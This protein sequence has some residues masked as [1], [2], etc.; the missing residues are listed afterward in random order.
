MEP[1]DTNWEPHAAQLRHQIAGILGF[2]AEKGPLDAETHRTID[3]GAYTI[4]PVTFASEP[5][6]RVTALLYLP[7]PLD[8]PVPGILVAAGH[9]GSK[10]ALSCQYTGQLYSLLGFAC[11]V[12]D[13]IGEEERHVERKMGTR[14]HDMYHF[15]TSE[16]RRAFVRT[17]LKR[18]VLGKIIWDLVRG[19]DYLESRPEID[20]ARLGAIGN[21]LGGATGGCVAVLDARVRAAIVSGWGFSVLGLDS[22]DCTSM[23]YEAFA[24]IMSFDEMTALLA[25]HAATVFIN[26]TRDSII[27]PKEDGAGLVRHVRSG[28]AGA[29]QILADAGVDGTIEAHFVPGACHR[30]Y[31]LTHPAAAWMQQHLMPPEARRPIPEGIVKY[32]D[33]VDACGKRIEELYDTEMRQRGARCVDIGAVY[34]SPRDLACFPERARPTP[35][36]TWQGWVERQTGSSAAE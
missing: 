16:E 25:P 33:W 28:I 3:G 8:G 14:A 35:E 22:K 21:S 18:L 19:L 13:T 23:P 2:P 34:R 20:P 24:E 17:E 36:Y 11:L 30:P 10:S 15:K 5:G 32:G 1:G 29:R 9:G 27:D 31:I 6:S 12:L 26:G 7:R 4:E